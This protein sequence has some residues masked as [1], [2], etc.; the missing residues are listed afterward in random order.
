MTSPEDSVKALRDALNV[1]PDNVPL[2]VHLADTLRKLGRGDEAE[3]EYRT[4]LSHQPNNADI[5]IGLASLYYEQGKDSHALVIIEDLVKQPDTPAQA[6]LLH[7]RLLLRAG[8]VRF[9]VTEYKAAI[10]A[11]PVVADAELED[12]LGIE[13]DPEESEVV[14][15]R[16]RAAWG[17]EDTTPEVVAERPEISFDQV[18]GMEPLKEEIRLKIIYPLTHAEMYQ[19]YGKQIGG[20]ILMYGPPGCGKTHLARATAGEIQAQFLAVGINDVLE[21]WIGNSE[22]NLHV[23]FQQAR[24]NAPCVLF[25]DEVDALGA[26]RS[27]MK[28]SAAR[29]LINQFLSEMDGVRDSNEGVLILAATNAPWHLDSAFRRPGRFDRVLFVPPPDATARAEILRIV[30]QGKPTEDIDHEH[31]AKKTPDFS[32]ADLQAVVDVAVEAKLR[33]AMKTGVPT[34][35]R[36]KD[37]LAAAKTVKP[38]TSEWFSTAR[39]YALYSNQGGT[40]DDIL[41]YLKLS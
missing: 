27:D 2:R 30:C 36:T 7:A 28:H 21:M 8:D 20:G 5:K 34:P 16:V 37:L 40:Y 10:E 9:A 22:R 41:K 39:N 26:S 31:V 25:F 15:G 19:A 13:A 6:Y 35:L 12:R 17:G 11:D 24:R 18:G 4:A 29:Q 33:D 14:D 1:S 32:G 3:K 38:T 23:W